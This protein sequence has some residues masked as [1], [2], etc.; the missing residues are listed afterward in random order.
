MAMEKATEFPK[1]DLEGAAL[2]PA[3]ATKNQIL[4][5][6]FGQLEKPW[7]P[8]LGEEGEW[9]FIHDVP[10]EERVRSVKP[11]ATKDECEVLLLVGLPGSGKSYW[12][13]EKQTCEP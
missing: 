11:P 3:I 5:I 2:F 7:Y 13:A 1:T 6:N 8:L 9:K 10:E 4:D 12:A